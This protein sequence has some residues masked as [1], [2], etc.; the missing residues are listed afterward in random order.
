LPVGV[1]RLEQRAEGGHLDDFVLAPA[2]EDHV[3][4]AKAPADDEGAAEVLLH[5]LGRGVG[6]DV[7]ILRPQADQQVAHG[8]ADDVGLIAGVLQRAHHADGVFI[9]QGGVDAVF[10]HRHLDTLAE[11][12]GGQRRRRGGRHGGVFALAEKAFDEFLDHS[13]SLRMGQ[14]RSDAMRASAGPGLVAT[15][16]L[17]RSS[18][19]RSFVESL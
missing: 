13:K 8:A 9:Q 12:D 10:G 15:G 1:G 14:P 5:L 17:T 4:D 2:A 11:R 7:E 19:G 3:H 6:G 16:S 18:S